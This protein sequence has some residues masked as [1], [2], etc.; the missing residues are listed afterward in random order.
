MGGKV[1]KRIINK[2]SLELY[3]PRLKCYD[4]ML[5]INITYAIMK[6]LFLRKTIKLIGIR[7]HHLGFRWQVKVEAAKSFEILLSKS[8][9]FPK[10][11]LACVE[12]NKESFFFGSIHSPY[13]L[14][15]KS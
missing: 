14:L 10:R 9:A 11:Q 12:I 15:A 4:N 6:I 7:L 13:Y 5:N 1:T 8:L 2:A 3:L